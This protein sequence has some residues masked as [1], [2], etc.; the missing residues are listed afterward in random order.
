MSY[1][2]KIK[3]NVKGGCDVEIGRLTCITG[4]NG[5]G[6]SRIVN[7]LELA[8]S[9][10]ASDIVGRPRV[11][12][13]LDLLDLAPP[14]KALSAQASLD[15]GRT[16]SLT[17]ERGKKEGTGKAPKHSPLYGVKVV[18]PIRDALAA[19]RGDV[20]KARDF[21]LSASGLSVSEKSI[22]KVLDPDL[23][24][25]FDTFSMSHDD[26]DSQIERLKAIREDAAKIARSAKAGAKKAQEIVDSLSSDLALEKPT[27]EEIEKANKAVGAAH[28]AY[29]KATEAPEV[30]DV[31]ALKAD[32]V[33]AIESFKADEWAFNDTK[34]DAERPENQSAAVQ[35]KLLPILGIYAQNEGAQCV[36]CQ[37][38]T[39]TGAAD[40]IV[41][42]EEAAQWEKARQAAIAALPMLQ[43]R[44]EQSKANAVSA[45]QAFK[46]H[47]NAEQPSA[48]D[49]Q[50]RIAEA[51]AALKK[52]ES[53]VSALSKAQGQWDTIEEARK[54]AKDSKKEA[55][56]AE[57]LAQYCA[58]ILRVLTR[59]SKEMFVANVQQFLPPTDVFDLVLQRG[60]R[61]VCMFGFRRDA[62]GADPEKGHL[63]TALSGAEWARLTIAL[64]C[65]CMEGGDD[66]VAVLTPEERAFDA[67]TLASVM[68]AL[69]EAPGQ[70]ILTSP[71]VPSTVPK[72]WTHICV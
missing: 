49:R 20:K 57:E 53:A 30:V 43:Q 37:Q 14:G 65:A 16:C 39:V 56:R 3:G 27:D 46:A 55:E 9:A 32:A 23:H 47:E 44:M 64:G 21:V 58:K 15:D 42:I 25:L 31:A 38:G 41:K 1:F 40:R 59:K 7:T 34:G 54:R 19:L 61:E 10:E 67:D 62:T 5:A 4:V 63:Q 68:E 35:M 13:G 33:K 17:I 45:I 36:L 12:K 66:V 50:K 52:A 11:K 60:K 2:H 18:Y 70:V 51:Y 69:T 28:A 26:K 22:K 72:E 29:T 71:V 24:D 48:E 6:K 8:A